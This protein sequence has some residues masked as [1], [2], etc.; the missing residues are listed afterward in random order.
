MY[1]TTRPPTLIK[2]RMGRGPVLAVSIYK[3]STDMT[4]YL[5]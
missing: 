2:H 1:V 5:Y 4:D 3:E